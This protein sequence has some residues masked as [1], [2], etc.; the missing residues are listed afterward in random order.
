MVTTTTQNTV[1][2]F[3]SSCMYKCVSRRITDYC[4]MPSD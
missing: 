1:L 2:K 3:N 4:L